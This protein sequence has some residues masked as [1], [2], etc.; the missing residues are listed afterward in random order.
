MM[1][2]LLL[3]LVA[4]ALVMG[5]MAVP[6]AA[7]PPGNPFVG[8]WETISDGPFGE[9]HIRTQIG[10]GGHIHL[11]TDLGQ[12]C[13]SDYEQRVPLSAFGWG[14]VINNDPYV[15]DGYVESYCHLRDGQGRQLVSDYFNVQFQYDPAT[16]TLISLHLDGGC[17]WRSGSD[18]SACDPE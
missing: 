9:E 1:K 8:S 15:W 4:V 5:V 12:I 7:G 10:D 6:L 18:P 16:D 13:Y 14:S 17:S 3:I 2:R 11:R